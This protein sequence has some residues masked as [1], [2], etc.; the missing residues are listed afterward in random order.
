MKS[1]RNQAG[2]VSLLHQSWKRA[3]KQSS[4]R[5]RKS[6]LSFLPFSNMFNTLID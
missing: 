4:Q 1:T 6:Q 5:A 3:G 2:G